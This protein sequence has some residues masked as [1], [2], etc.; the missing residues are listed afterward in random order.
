M[1]KDS[2]FWHLRKRLKHGLIS[3]M[4][5]SKRMHHNELMVFSHN[6]FDLPFIM[7]TIHLRYRTTN[8]NE[9]ISRAEG[10]K[11]I[12]RNHKD[13][14]LSTAVSLNVLQSCSLLKMLEQFAR[15][16]P[17]RRCRRRWVVD[18]GI[19]NLYDFVYFCMRVST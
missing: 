7:I 6:N 8:T 14:P 11:S 19:I 5:I 16:E 13:R 4:V 1:S 15:N 2:Y 9:K 17:T 3:N 18:V 10:K 12:G